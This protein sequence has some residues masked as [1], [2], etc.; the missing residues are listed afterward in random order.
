MSPNFNPETSALLHADLLAQSGSVAELHVWQG[1]VHV[2]PSNLALLHAAREAL[3]IV[4]DFLRR[5]LAR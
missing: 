4:G 2:F 1:M 5:H 3:D